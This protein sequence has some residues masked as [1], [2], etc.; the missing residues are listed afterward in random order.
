MGR[1][2]AVLGIRARTNDPAHECPFGL[3]ALV[4]LDVHVKD[5]LE[6]V[7]VAAPW[8]GVRV[9]MAVVMPVVLSVMVTTLTAL[10]QIVILRDGV[11]MGVALLQ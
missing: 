11:G 1:T 8:E 9:R 10:L 7:Y 6:T 5:V 4:K 3:D 2:A